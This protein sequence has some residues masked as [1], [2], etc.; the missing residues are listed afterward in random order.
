MI[1]PIELNK[2]E[3]LK[4]WL[5]KVLP[6]HLV[7][8]LVYFVTRLQGPVV[9]PLIKWFIRK[10]NV[11]MSDSIHPD[12]GDYK[13]FNDFFTR[14]L[15][16]ETRPVVSGA[17]TIACPVDGTVSV[18]GNIVEQSI[19][20]AKGHQYTV[21]KLLGGDPSL[22]A[23]FKNGRFA[24]IYLAPYNYHRIHMPISGVLKNM[25][26]VPGRLFSVAPWTVSAI[27][28]LFAGNERVVCLFSTPAGP[29]G[30]VLV[31]AINVAAIETI[32][33]GLITPPKGKKVSAF[34]YS[35][36]SKQYQKGDEMGRFNM[37]STVILLA[38]NNVE[39]VQ[40]LRPGQ[41]MKMG[42]L[43]G[44]FPLPKAPTKPV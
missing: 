13:T 7:S 29:I 22:S 17:N 20:Q 11:D 12:P 33:A 15:K 35:H 23:L 30:M 1:K 9:Q 25:I 21:R 32:W 10:F 2:K 27:P 38:R 28:G 26:H 40:K 36:T 34:D 19:F 44:R 43:I 5:F 42:E 4:I 41:V 18:A 3:K 6:H 14:A 16:P 39:W 8:R 31:G 37:G 24:T